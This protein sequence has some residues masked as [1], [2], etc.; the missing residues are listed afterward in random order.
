MRLFQNPKYR[1]MANRKKALIF[2]GTLLLL[3]V[4]S[5][6][7]HGGPR[8]GIDFRGGTSIELRFEDK[9]D[10][11]K[12]LNIPIDQVR[13]VF[14]EAGLGRSTIKHFGSP[15][16]ILVQVDV[17][18]NISDSLM[19]VIKSGF[20][21]VYPDYQ[22]IER[23]RETVGPTIGAELK[24]KALWAVL[25]SLLLILV[26]IMF[27][28]ELRFGVGAVLALFHDILITLG[29]FS[30]FDIEITTAVVAALLT[31]VGY[32]LNDTIVVFDRIRENLK[33]LHRKVSNYGDIV[34]TSLN[35]TL[36][37]T[38]VTSLTTMLVVVI[39]YIFGGEILKSF[40]FALICGITV[41]TYSSI[42][43]A[44]PI[45]VEWETRKIAKAS[46]AKK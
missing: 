34:D 42:F 40:A 23:R 18:K 21:K 4:V 1:F 32:S 28:F 44:S 19:A 8:F 31:I 45:L 27:R 6:I 14:S 17:S 12:E 13:K 33:T 37:R 22:M 15:Q 38:V 3:S 29:V 25:F 39:L 10:P 20:E 2:S 26:Y 43:V 41:G 30:L 7:V 9:A 35:E 24:W 36:S 16:E 11:A 5:L 46:G